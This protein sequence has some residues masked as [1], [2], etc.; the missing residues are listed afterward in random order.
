ML[1]NRSDIRKAAGPAL[2][3]ICIG[4]E[5]GIDNIRESPNVTADD[6]CKRWRAGAIMNQQRKIEELQM[7]CILEDSYND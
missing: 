6:G 7:T 2:F 4:S 5:I 3:D 1:A